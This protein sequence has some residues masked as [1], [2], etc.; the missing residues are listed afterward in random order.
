MFT[1][2]RHITCPNCLGE[3]TV[4][5]ED[6]GSLKM[7]KMFPREPCPECNG[8]GKVFSQDEDDATRKEE[9]TKDLFF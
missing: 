1:A 6:N 8:R 9:I 7:S 3:K 5:R 2:G 4:A